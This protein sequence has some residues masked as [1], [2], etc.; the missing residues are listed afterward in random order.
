MNYLFLLFTIACLTYA[1][2]KKK[3]LWLLAPI[4]V[5]FA[6]IVVQILLVPLPLGETLT[7]IFNLR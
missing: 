1:L 7:F 5:M 6:Y 3:F 2:V 4:G